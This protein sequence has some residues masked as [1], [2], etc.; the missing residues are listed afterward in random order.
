MILSLYRA[1]QAGGRTWRNIFTGSQVRCPA[2]IASQSGRCQVR[3]CGERKL[4]AFLRDTPDRSRSP[5][6]IGSGCGRPS[7]NAFAS[8]TNPQPLLLP[9]H[10]RADRKVM[11]AYVRRQGLIQDGHHDVGR[12][13]GHVEH[14][15]HV[16]VVD[17][18][19]GREFGDEFR[20]AG[21]KHRQP[22]MAAG[23]RQLHLRDGHIPGPGLY[24]LTIRQGTQFPP[25]AVLDLNRYLWRQP[26]VAGRDHTRCSSLANAKPIYANASS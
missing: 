22:T 6:P 8:H 11:Y 7:L 26:A 1:R 17:L 19:A 15:A 18:L 16:A 4:N 3:C 25:A 21:F 20:F 13:R 12:E 24:S 2:S 5:H 9:Q 14:A 23:E 10:Q